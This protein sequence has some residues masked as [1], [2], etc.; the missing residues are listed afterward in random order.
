MTKRY[1]VIAGN[2]GVGKST[3]TQFLADRLGW[4]P[5]F[6]PFEANPYLSDFYADMPRWAFQSQ[7]FFLSRRLRMHRQLITHPG[8]V[9]QDRS[10]YE[11]AEIF[12]KNLFRQGQIAER[13]YR[14]Y[15]E[16]YDV[17]LEFL[18]APDLVVYLRADVDTLLAR[19]GQ[20]GRT[21]EQDIP[22]AYVAQLNTLY[23]EWASSFAMCPI[24]TV[25]S[26]NL[27]F[28]K[29]PA[30]LDL[31]VTKVQERLQGKETVSFD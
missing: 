31:I 29:H 19:I 7:M 15:R 2:I 26:H 14:C 28:V 25:P 18:P 30:H 27:D 22:R 24:L 12:A 1:I 6:E 10:V 11:D 16:L 3:L 20:R 23:E 5:F 4:T 13:D 8:T 9:L 17:L 21:Y